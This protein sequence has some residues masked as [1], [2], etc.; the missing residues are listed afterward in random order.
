[1]FLTKIVS[2]LCPSIMCNVRIFL[3]LGHYLLISKFDQ[4]FCNYY[5]RQMFYLQKQTVI[6]F[7]EFLN[8]FRSTT[9]SQKFLQIVVI[10]FKINTIIS[11]IIFCLF[12]LGHPQQ[13]VSLPKQVGRQGD[14]FSFKIWIRHRTLTYPEIKKIIHLF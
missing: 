9:N 4:I 6:S 1:M 10:D 8:K 13:N 2:E 7:G 12:S 3:V 11:V 14:F 5:V